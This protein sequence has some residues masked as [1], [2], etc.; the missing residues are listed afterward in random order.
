L[1][2]VPS[3]AFSPDGRWLASAGRDGTVRLWQPT[4]GRELRVLAAHRG[5]A[6]AVAFTPDGK[7]LASAGADRTIR[8][9]DVSTGVEKR[10]C[11]GH[12]GPVTCLALSHDGRIIAS[13]AQDRTIRLWKTATGAEM[14]R[15]PVEATPVTSLAFTEGDKALASG[16]ASGRGHQADVIR[17]WDVATGKPLRQFDGRGGALA[18]SADGEKLAAG[19]VNT[20][21]GQKTAGTVI[22]GVR[23][24]KAEFTHVWQTKTGREL[25]RLDG[26]LAALAPNGKTLAIR[27]SRW[28]YDGNWT[29]NSAGDP[30]WDTIC[31]VDAATGERLASLQ[32]SSADV[33]AF[34]T[35]GKRLAVAGMNGTII[36]WSLGD[37]T[38]SQPVPLAKR[39][40]EERK[41]LW[42]DLA[43]DHA[44]HARRAMATLIAGRDSAVSFLAEPLR[45]IGKE[46]SSSERRAVLRAVEVLEHI[47]TEQARQVLAGLEREAP[48]ASLRREARASLE[49]LKKTTHKR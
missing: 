6:F 14:R 23:M 5:G 42:D 33:A 22:G 21:V 30:A 32:A 9:W 46:A 34:S 45:S 38:R 49:R 25:L 31:L 12:T 19:G 18:F 10:R 1:P 11:E 48:D 17:F 20:I 2:Q 16:G 28:L 37:T 8:L 47:G 40:V 41:Q 4:S 29:G 3:L 35:D 44:V 36:L 13:G 43:G 27:S 26:T 7:T 15:I 39:P 24:G